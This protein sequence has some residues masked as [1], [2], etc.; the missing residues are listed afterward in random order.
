VFETQQKNTQKAKY[1]FGVMCMDIAQEIH[2]FSV[3]EAT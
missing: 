1:M 2:V 3:V